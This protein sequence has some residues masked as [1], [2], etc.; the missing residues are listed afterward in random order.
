MKDKYEKIMILVVVLA[1]GLASAVTN[2]NL[3]A[4]WACDDVEGG[5]ARDSVGGNDGI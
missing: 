5:I 2:A 3:V 4:Y 1:M